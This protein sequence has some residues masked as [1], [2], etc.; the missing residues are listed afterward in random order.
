L[1][2][3]SIPRRELQDIGFESHAS[4]CEIIERP[5]RVPLFVPYFVIED[6]LTTVI[7]RGRPCDDEI[8]P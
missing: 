6:L 5:R 4:P 1:K 7:G 8:G 2:Q 3:V